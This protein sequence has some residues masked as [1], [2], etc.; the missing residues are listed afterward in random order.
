M[1]NEV[2]KVLDF[3]LIPGGRLREA[4]GGSAQEFF[5]DYIKPILDTKKPDRLT[6]DFSGTWGYGPS[7]TS[8][9]GI[10]LTEYLK[11]VK[12][13][14]D[15]VSIVASDN[16]AAVDSFWSQLEDIK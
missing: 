16:P 9:L 1:K 4:G 12:T 11:S 5:E 2:V 15:K 8:Q 6:I 10:F 13:V 3:T 14:R 7:F